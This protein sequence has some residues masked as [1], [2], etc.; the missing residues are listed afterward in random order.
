V[1]APRRRTAIPPTINTAMPITAPR[2][3]VTPADP[4]AV[5]LTRHGAS[6]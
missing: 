6:V 5:A 4:V 1:N 3:N 2:Q